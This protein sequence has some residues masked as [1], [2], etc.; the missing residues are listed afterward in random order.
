[1][2]SLIVKR[3]INK[4][5]DI[6]NI[7]SIFDIEEIKYHSIS[8]VNWREYP[9][10]PNVNFRIAHDGTTI[11]LN[12]QVDESDIQ[13]VC[14]KDGGEVWNDSCV[15][16]FLSFDGKM[17]YNIESNCIGKI[18]IATGTDRNDRIS[19]SQEL[20]RKVQRY[21]SLGCLPVKNLTGKWELS[22]L[23]P[24]DIFYLSHINNLDGIHAKGNF[25]KCG[26][27]LKV[28]HFLS[29]NPINSEVPNFH[30]SNF[31]G[32]LEFEKKL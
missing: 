16:F 11:Y 30:L 10:K 7:P 18:L 25:Y 22:L 5:L 2:N 23:I 28:P 3:L 29:W 26:D 20:I 4:P 13:A 27:K 17:Y 15:E 32:K 24:I 9:Y 31:F 6:A 12:Y 8:D 19:L 14:D 21:S 1:M